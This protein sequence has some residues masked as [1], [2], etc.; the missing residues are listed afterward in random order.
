MWRLTLR[1]DR[2]IS[3]PSWK[4]KTSCR[5]PN[6]PAE[7]L[8]GSWER[9]NSSRTRFAMVASKRRSSRIAP[10]RDLAAVSVIPCAAAPP[11]AGPS[12]FFRASSRTSVTVSTMAPMLSSLTR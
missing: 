8:A 4:R 1:G 10:R 7:S 9:R 5:K 11:G 6:S 12:P 2:T 3:A